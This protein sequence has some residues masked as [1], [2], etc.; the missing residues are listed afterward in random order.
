MRCSHTNRKSYIHVVRFRAIECRDD[1]NDASLLV[2]RHAVDAH[3]AVDAWLVIHI[4]LVD[5]VI[6]DI[7]FVFSRNL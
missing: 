3:F 1:R 5:T 6:H 2:E 7:P 4:V